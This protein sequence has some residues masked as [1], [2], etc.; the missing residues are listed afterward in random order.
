[1]SAKLKK[2]SQ[3][4]KSIPAAKR[5]QRGSYRMVEGPGKAV[6]VRHSPRR[7]GD[8]AN[9]TDTDLLLQAMD[10]GWEKAER[11]YYRG[12]EEGYEKG[13]R[14]G[15][16]QGRNEA[17]RAVNAFEIT[18]SS[19][20]TSLLQFYSGLERWAVKLAMRIAEKVIGD[21]AGQHADLVHQTVRRAIAE[22]ADK[23][24]ILIKVNPADYEAVKELRSSIT[25]LSEGIEH[26]KIEADGNITPGSCRIE[27][28]SGLLDADFTTQ[29]GQLRR[30]LA[31]HEEAKA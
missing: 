14:E 7:T 9:F 19:L 24:R 27:T 12:L 2:L 17:E 26:F 21:A 13:L 29:I 31:L 18:L 6:I 30:A 5:L 20:E 1:M 25:S 3:E 15:L 16:A 22:A 28:P 11:A 8:L 10:A 4:L 23:T